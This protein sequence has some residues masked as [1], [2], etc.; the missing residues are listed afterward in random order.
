MSGKALYLEYKKNT[1][2]SIIKEKI[3]VKWTNCLDRHVTKL[4]FPGGSVA[5]N[6]PANAGD[7]GLLPEL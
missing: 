6:P 3:N 1:Q 2:N 4:G 5:K 7:V